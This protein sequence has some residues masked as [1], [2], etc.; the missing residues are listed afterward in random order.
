MPEIRRS[1]LMPYPAQFMYDIVNDVE[2]YP[3][4]LPWCGDVK[5]SQLDNSS[6]EAS[7]LMRGAGLNHWFKT[8]NSMVPGQSI[9]MELV[10]GPFSKLDGLWSFTSI[11]S[12]G[13]KIELMLQFEM[14]QG[15]AST[16]IAPAFSRIANTMV[17]SFCERARNRYER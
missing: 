12:D 13:C 16:L 11:D 9:E 17:D 10:E 8:R 14:K 3:E 15:L 6:M 4:F 7:I 2:S 5:I 1:A